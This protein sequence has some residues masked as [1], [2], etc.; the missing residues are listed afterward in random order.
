MDFLKKSFFWKEAQY[1]ARIDSFKGGTGI[2]TF[3]YM[4]AHVLEH[5]TI[6]QGRA[7]F[8]TFQ[9]TNEVTICIINIHARNY[10]GSRTRLWN[11]IRYYPLNANWVLARD[12]NMLK[13]LKDKQGGENTTGRDPNKVI[14][15]LA[16]LLHLRLHDSYLLDKFRKLTTKR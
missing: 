5:G 8:I 1:S 3:P 16:L 6:V 12:F 2:L 11:R 13:Q 4:A 7:Q 9:L 10:I 14:A 15:W